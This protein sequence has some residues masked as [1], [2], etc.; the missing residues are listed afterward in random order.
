MRKRRKLPPDNRLDWRDPNMPVLDDGLEK[1]PE[2]F[3]RERLR[4]LIS[5]EGFTG[6]K[7]FPHYKNDPS[8]FW[9]EI[10]KRIDIKN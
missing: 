7:H 5:T 2:Q 1:T 3:Q 9:A 10:K 6:A 4:M 8:Y